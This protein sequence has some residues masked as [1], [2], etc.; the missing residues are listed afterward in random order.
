MTFVQF[1]NVKGFLYEV[2]H[3]M[4]KLKPLGLERKFHKSKLV[5]LKPPS[6]TFCGKAAAVCCESDH[7]RTV[8]KILKACRFRLGA[9]EA[10]AEQAGMWPKS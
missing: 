9:I 10:G 6:P 3:R 1:K 4:Q 2:V 5:V 7:K 8:V